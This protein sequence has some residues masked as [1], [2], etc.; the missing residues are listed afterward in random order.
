M[1]LETFLFQK[2]AQ[3]RHN[4]CLLCKIF[5]Q[6]FTA[7]DHVRI[8]SQ[9]LYDN[10]IFLFLFKYFVPCYFQLMFIEMLFHET[11]ETVC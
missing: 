5:H 11:V 4:D 2:E 9:L 3:G 8:M 7:V 10:K 1:G 6:V